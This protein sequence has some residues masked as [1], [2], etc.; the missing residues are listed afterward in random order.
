[1][2]IIFSAFALAL[3]VASHAVHAQDASIQKGSGIDLVR[4]MNATQ[5]EIDQATAPIK[6]KSDL[7]RYL[8]TTPDSPLN[9]LP[10]KLRDKFL[11]SLVFTRH[12]LAS[13][14][15][16]GLDSASTTD[17]YA[18]FSLFGQQRYLTS[19]PGLKAKN[20]TEKS[21]LFMSA[22]GGGGENTTEEPP[23][24]N[25]YCTVDGQDSWC[26]YEYGST[27]NAKCK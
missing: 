12:G 16:L 2:K 19:I 18:I 14:S 9:K 20:P 25:A 23:V 17:L 27:C 15:Y 3:C 6:S 4:E 13:Y 7:E 11:K 24:Q 5:I 22:M 10:P 1:M 21:I 26:T 8:R